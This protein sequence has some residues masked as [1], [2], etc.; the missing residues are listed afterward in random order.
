MLLSIVTSPGMFGLSSLRMLRKRSVSGNV[1][2]LTVLWFKSGATRVV[3]SDA[4]DSGYGGYSVEVGQQF[5]QGSWLEHEAQLSSTW[6]ELKAVY[7]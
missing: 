5:V 7:Q 3:Y 4:S 1:A 6:R 2:T